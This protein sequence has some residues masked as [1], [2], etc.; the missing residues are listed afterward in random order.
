MRRTLNILPSVTVNASDFISDSGIQTGIYPYPDYPDV[1]RSPPVLASLGIVAKVE[2]SSESPARGLLSYVVDLKLN[3]ARHRRGVAGGVRVEG[4]AERDRGPVGGVLQR[5]RA[6]GG[7]VGGGGH[8]GRHPARV[9]ADRFGIDRRHPVAPRRLPA[10]PGVGP[11]G[12]RAPGVLHQHGPVRSVRRPL[13]AVAGDRRTAA[14]ESHG[15]KRRS[16]SPPSPSQSRGWALPASSA[17]RAGFPQTCRSPRHR[18]RT[19]PARRSCCRPS[20][21]PYSAPRRPGSPR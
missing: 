20:S 10:E 7:V 13:D 14:L 5:Q 19:R 9:G 6:Q 3:A 8:G 21:G 12:V 4:G 16:A 18:C 2:S 17:R 1:V 15:R 11:G